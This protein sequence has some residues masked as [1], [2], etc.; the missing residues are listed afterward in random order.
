MGAQYKS[1]LKKS[2]GFTIAELVVVVVVIVI[3]ATVAIIGFGSWQASTERTVLESDLRAAATSMDTAANFNN[4]YPSTLPTTYEPSDKTTVSG[5]AISGTNNY[6]V[7]AT[8]DD[9][10]YFMT[11]QKVFL[12]GVCP[13]V[14]FSPSLSDSY[15]SGT[16]KINDISG[17]EMIATFRQGATIDTIGPTYLPNEAGGVMS[18]DGENEYSTSTTVDLGPNTTWTTCAKTNESLSNYNMFMGHRLPDFGSYYYGT[19]IIFSNSIAGSQ[20]TVTSMS[21]AIP[22]NTWHCYAF[23]TSYDGTSTTMTIYLDGEFRESA[24][25]PGQQT[26]SAYTFTVGDGYN[27]TTSTY[28]WYPF[29][30][31]V[32]DVAIYPKTLSIEEIKEIYTFQRKKMGI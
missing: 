8:R 24:T 11:K 7:E 21:P 9:V 6:C 16:S 17:H 15:Q 22:L 20:R 23:T 26:N 27:S 28:K 29:N 14:Y 13:L 3:L 4:S 2:Q 5:G 19:S 12:P 25:F 18:F 31:Q 32:G 30:G 1:S 10:S